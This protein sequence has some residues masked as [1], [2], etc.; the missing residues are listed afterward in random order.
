M[1][2]GPQRLLESSLFLPPTP[3]S[4]PGPRVTPSPLGSS[5]TH[6]QAPVLFPFLR[7]KLDRRGGMRAQ[8]A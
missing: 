5:L 7:V 3:W 6:S 8:A 2:V 4:W 1:G